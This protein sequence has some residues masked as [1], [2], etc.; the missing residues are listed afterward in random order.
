MTFIMNLKKKFLAA[1]LGGAMLFTGSQ[2]LANPAEFPH[3]PMNQEQIAE[4]ISGWVNH[5]SAE[6]GVDTAQVEQALKDGVHIRDV[7]YAAII[8]KLSGKSFSEVLAMKMDWVQV[9][10]KLGVT[11]EQFKDFYRQKMSEK[12]AQDAFTDVKTVQSLIKDGYNPK[13]IVIAGKIANAAGKDIK[14][15]LSKR[16]IN[17]TWGDVAKSFGVDA[18][19]VMPPEPEQTDE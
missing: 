2:A 4:N 10:K 9:A 8:S 13:D 19:K 3:M 7:Q 6:Y 17:N 14:S 15:V 18:Y 1:V 5:L 16:K 12:L 11:R